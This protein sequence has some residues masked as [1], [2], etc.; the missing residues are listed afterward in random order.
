MEEQ[1]QNDEKLKADIF[2]IYSKYD[3]SSDRDK[4]DLWEL[5]TRWCRY[6]L[7]PKQTKQL[8]EKEGKNTEK[9]TN[10]EIGL[11]IFRQEM[12]PYI[13]KAIKDCAEKDKMP[14]KEFF[15]YLYTALKNAVIQYVRDNPENLIK[16][17]RTLRE[18]KILLTTWEKIKGREPTQDERYNYI[19]GMMPEKKDETI[20]EYLVQ[21]DTIGEN[22]ISNTFVDDDGNKLNII[23]TIESHLSIP[24][25]EAIEDSVEEIIK[26]ELESLLNKYKD[27]DKPFY[28]A[29]LTTRF[30]TNDNDKKYYKKIMSILDEE[31]I[32]EYEKNGKIPN[33]YEIY[34]NVYNV[35]KSSAESGASSKAKEFFKSLDKTEKSIYKEFEILYKKN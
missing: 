10:E 11:L 13:F 32:K 14:K 7:F 19:R 21:M 25:Y 29:L 17:T 1:K 3:P 6:Y 5:V 27:K 23:D 8:I 24:H 9:R 16:E 12:S 22:T 33:Q 2:D 26:N 31:I 35:K 20:R 28:R 15:S 4:L 18:I 30:L 34:M